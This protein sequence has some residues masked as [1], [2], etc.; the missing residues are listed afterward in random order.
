MARKVVRG[1][2]ERHLDNSRQPARRDGSPNLRVV[3]SSP[4]G[5]PTQ[6][7][8]RCIYPVARIHS[9]TIGTATK[10]RN[11]TT[12]IRHPDRLCDTLPCSATNMVAAAGSSGR[13]GRR[14]KSCHPDQCSRRPEAPTRN[15]E[16]LSCCQ[17]STKRNA[18]G[19]GEVLCEHAPTPGASGSG[20][21]P[22]SV[23]RVPHAGSTP[24]MTVADTARSGAPVVWWPR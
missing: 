16:G 3:G 19:T 8:R 10:Y 22:V 12:A 21:V 5:P 24:A 9:R 14:F 15:G 23:V 20:V 2:H 17:Y 18:E 7:W 1:N 6:R 11:T 13:R 4:T